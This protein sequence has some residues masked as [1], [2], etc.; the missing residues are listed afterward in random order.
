MIWVSRTEYFTQA[1]A[2]GSISAGT[3]ISY[4]S[5]T[6]AVSLDISAGDGIEINNGNEIAL[7]LTA[8]RY[9]ASNVS[10]TANTAYTVTHN[11]GVKLVHVSALRTSDSARVDL[12][13]V[14][15]STSALTVKA[16]SNLTVDIAVSV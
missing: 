13:V 8:V 11:L 15:S 6:G 16:V 3:G 4:N 12:E 10:L 2:R 14:Y 1:R 5:G 9:S 7:D